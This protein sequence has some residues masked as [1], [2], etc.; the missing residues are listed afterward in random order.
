MQTDACVTLGDPRAR[1][2]R[3]GR[4]QQGAPGAGRQSRRGRV[5]PLAPRGLPP[6]RPGR[7]RALVAPGCGDRRASRDRRNVV[8]ATGTASGKSLCYQVPIV[9]SIAGG[10]RDTALLVFPTKAL[11]QDQLRTFREWLVPD[12]VAATYDGDTPSDERTWI[13]NARQRRA[14]QPRDAAHGDPARR[15]IAGRRSSCACATS[16]STSC[17]PC[18]AS[19]AAT[20]RTCCGGSVVCASTTAP[21]PTFCFT[22]ATIGNPAEL[23]S[24]LCGLPVEAIDGDGSPQAERSF[25]VWQRP[26]VDVHYGHARVG[27]RRD[28][29]AAVALRRRRAPDA[30]VHPQPQGRR[31][32]RHARAR[33]A[34]RAPRPDVAV[35]VAGGRRVPRRLSRRRAARARGAAR[36][37]RARRCRRHE[38]ARARHRRRFARRGGAQRLP[39][40]ARVDAPA[41][42]AGGAYDRRAAAVLIAGD[43]QLDQWYAAPSRR[44]A[45]PSRPRRWS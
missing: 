1:A 4:Q 37:R 27:E 19:S 21:S 43:D 36:E 3:P 24:R 44:A 40:H 35:A 14:H 45:R 13:R 30:R 23:A 33:H 29:D 16:S 25:A 8:V 26:L 42:R 2:L 15:T 41:G 22:S 31:A 12:L 5:H 7:R 18:A 38:R 28:R 34:G 6:A 32:R 9:E 11:A 17:T 10:G 39:G 20:S